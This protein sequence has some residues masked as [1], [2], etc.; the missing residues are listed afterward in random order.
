M[1]LGL[2]I[3]PTAHPLPALI[4]QEGIGGPVLVGAAREQAV[5][6]VADV[7]LGAAPH[8]SVVFIRVDHAGGAKVLDAAHRVREVAVPVAGQVA[9]GAVDVGLVDA[10]GVLGDDDGGLARAD[11]GRDRARGRGRERVRVRE[12]ESR[13]DEQSKSNNIHLCECDFLRGFVRTFAA[14]LASTER[15]RLVSALRIASQDPEETIFFLR[16]EA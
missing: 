3:H 4:V 10:V 2:P 7:D 9:V 11:R 8:R 6:V 16:F 14:C 1:V 13:R 15:S 12:H 5:G